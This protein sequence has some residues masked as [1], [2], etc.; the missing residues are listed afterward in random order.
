MGNGTGFLE[1][2][3]FVHE[4]IERELNSA[5]PDAAT[6]QQVQAVVKQSLCGAMDWS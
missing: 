5:L 1:E 4:L 2:V 6:K 3:D